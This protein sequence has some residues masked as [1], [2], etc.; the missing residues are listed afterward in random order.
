[1]DGPRLANLKSTASVLGC[2]V[3][4]ALAANWKGRRLRAARSNGTRWRCAQWLDNSAQ[5]EVQAPLEHCFQLWED[6]ELIPNWMPWITSVKVSS[7]R[8]SAIYD[9]LS[10]LAVLSYA[11]CV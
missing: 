9:K 4:V 8:L 7:R 6:R 1:M 3:R 10:M 5:T 11:Q 2:A